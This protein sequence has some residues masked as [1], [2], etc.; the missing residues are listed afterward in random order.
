MRPS[1]LLAALLL[2]AALAAQQS[3]AKGTVVLKA[4]RLIDGTGAPVVQNGVVVV[5][6]DRI[7]AVGAE[8]SVAISAGARVID[9]G[10]ATLLPGFIDAHVHIIGRPL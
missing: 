8:A 7:V 9:L 5:T 6:D 10:D 1:A 4:A 2:P 3:P